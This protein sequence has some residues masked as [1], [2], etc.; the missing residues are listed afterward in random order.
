MNLLVRILFLVLLTGGCTSPNEEINL[1]PEEAGQSPNYWCTWYWQNYLINKGQAVSVPDAQKIFTNQAARD[2]LNE[3]SIFGNNGMAVVVL[4][5]TRSDFYFLID[6]G[7]QNKHLTKNTF[8]TSIMDTLDFPRYAHLT[9]KN[10]IKQ[11]NT[12]IKALG[13]KGLGLWFRGNLSQ[14]KMLELISW[15]KDAGIEYWKIDGGDIS[16]YY[17]S[18]IKKKLYPELWLEHITGTGPLNSLWNVPDLDYYPSVYSLTNQVTQQL[19]SEAG[20]TLNKKSQKA[21]KSFDVIKNTDV[22]R[23]YDAAPLLVSTV[24]LGRVHDILTHTAGK[25]EY[26]AFLNVQDDCNI[27]AALGLTVAVKRHPMNTPRLYK[28]Q[29]Y[30]A[31]IAGNRHVDRRLSEMDRFARWQRIAPPMEAGYSSYHYSDH[32]LIDSIVFERHHT[33]YAPSHGK[34]VRQSAPAIMSRNIALPKVQTKG[35]APYVMASKFPNGA[36]A[37]ATEGR[38]TPD[39][40]WYEPK[41]DISMTDVTVDT[42]IG[43]F[44]HY[45]S[46]HLQFEKPLPENIK[47]FAQDLLAKAAIDITNKVS[48]REQQ[49]VL[50]GQLI[51]D[52]GTSENGANDISV[53]GLVIQV[54]TE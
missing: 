4:P 18:Q 43:V 26:K 36:I 22:F 9:P 25:A 11:M 16:Q 8:F 53:P 50:P 39:N 32:N 40:S 1:V 24:T 42:P 21:I 45:A 33:W 7:W 19:Q 6:H 14:E 47:V 34:M 41:A 23:T 46:L 31:Q 10:R 2:E 27:A 29:D 51:N 15:S 44:G 30:H 5:K 52:I 20:T 3:E 12:D 35:L 54:I 48:I 49:I 17:A 13:W 37:I 28:G 38:V